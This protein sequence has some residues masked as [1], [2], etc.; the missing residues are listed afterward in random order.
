M[1]KQFPYYIE[2][3]IL[4]L[5][6]HRDDLGNEVDFPYYRSW[7]IRL[8]NYDINFI[9]RASEALQNNIGFTD[10]QVDTAV[11]IITK[12]KKQINLK[13]GRNVDYISVD[14]PLRIAM[15][16]VDKTFSI[17]MHS[18]HYEV[19]FPYLPDLVDSMHKMSNTS[20]GN[21][22]WL[23]DK[24]VWHV[25]KTERNLSVIRDFVQTHSKNS[26]FIDSKVQEQFDEVDRIRKNF[27]QYVPYLDIDD[28]GQLA[29]Y[30][31]NESL[32]LALNNF[33]FDDDLPNAAIRADN[34]G[35]SI[36]TRL[37]DYIKQQYADIAIPLLTSQKNVFSLG[38]LLNVFVSLDSLEKFMTTVRADYWIFVGFNRR[39]QD[40]YM[41]YAMNINTV[42]EKIFSLRSQ[43]NSNDNI[44]KEI[45]D[46][47]SRNI[48]LFVDNVALMTRILSIHGL[49]NKPMLRI[50][51][52]QGNISSEKVQNHS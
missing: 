40:A 37:A 1:T 38:K 17:T 36:G 24:K 29:V 27:Y 42:G 12:Y 46:L 28:N 18:N 35:L 11:T 13:L 30:N 10:R 48:V 31:S 51:Y 33:N 20:S 52:L 44:Y 41:E 21:Y 23:K 49:L 14:R 34:F 16:E 50:M 19:K 5:G 3:W 25:S 8:A 9:S 4:W 32:D 39:S 7:P 26:W 22:Y 2:D 45:I 47:D 43:F 15:R 6:K